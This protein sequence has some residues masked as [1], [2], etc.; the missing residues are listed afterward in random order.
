MG[1]GLFDFG[2]RDGPFED[3]ELQH[4]L[5]VVAAEPSKILIA[6][7]YNHKLK[8]LNVDERSVQ[9]LAGTGIP[10]RGHGEGLRAQM[11]EPGGLAVLGK[12]VL[13]ADTNNH[14]IMQYDM[15]SAQLSEWKLTVE[16]RESQKL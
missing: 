1:T 5:G 6:D 2:D 15:E 14:R 7:T 13:I 16:E 9:T 12:Q 10:G 4:V 8:L 11:N 3:A